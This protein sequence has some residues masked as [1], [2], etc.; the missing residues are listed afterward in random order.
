MTKRYE[1][2]GYQYGIDADGI[3]QS[4]ENIPLS[5]C[6]TTGWCLYV[7]EYQSTDPNDDTW[8]EVYDQNFPT[9][10]SYEQVREEL[11]KRYPGAEL[12]EY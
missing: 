5:H 3:Q 12:D 7:R 10:S 1:I 9:R 6:V 8:D 11:L 4:L 2:C